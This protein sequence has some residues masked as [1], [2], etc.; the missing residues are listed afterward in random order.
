[1]RLASIRVRDFECFGADGVDVAIDDI[2]V[3]I[4]PNNVGKSAILDAYEV[5]ASSGSELPLTRFCNEVADSP[6]EITGTFVEITEGD[7]E[8]I[9]E[10]WI[11]S[12]LKHGECVKV[13][14]SWSNPGAKG[15]KSSWNNES[16][17]WV[18][19]GVGGWDSLFASCIPVPIRISPRDDPTTT[20]SKIVE[21]LT[22]A[23]KAKLKSDT[24][25][26]AAILAQLEELS[27]KFGAEIQDELD[28]TCERVSERLRCVFPDYSIEFI[29]AAGKFEPEKSVGTGSH[30][31]I[32]RGTEGAIPL[33]SQGTGLQRTFLWSA[34][35]ALAEQGK[36]KVGKSAVTPE[37]PKMLLIDEP[38]AFLHPPS[39]RAAREVLYDIAS[40]PGWQVMATTHSAVFI[41]VSKPHTTIVRLERSAGAQGSR[42]FSTDKAT[43]DGDERDRLRM[44]RSCNPTVTEFFFADHVFLVEGETEHLVLNVLLSRISEPWAGTRHVVN[45]MGKANIPLFA[46]I[47]NQFGIAYTAIHD[48]DAPQVRRNGKW[49]RNGMWTMNQR[50]S[51]A[52]AQHPDAA[53]CY[54]IVHVPDF[55]GY[56]FG[57]R[58]TADKPFS[59]VRELM[60][61][62]FQTADE[63]ARLRSLVK[64]L[65]GE[66]H[67]NT[68]TGMDGLILK[69]K[70]YVQ[71][72]SPTPAEAWTIDLPSVDA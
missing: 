24:G 23:V 7:K 67:P 47:L 33:N 51:E 38:E 69:V 29:P 63:L 40:V 11:H 26:A 31:R 4:G 39:V 43:F 6:V 46:R 70:E 41:D 52:V 8:K 61:S 2:V 27:K 49:Q 71:V 68:Y 14:W 48:A 44:I 20:E 36:L 42:V 56:Y 62:D 54:K 72:E 22:A 64:I 28:A 10:K 59:A 58:L 34:L 5:F 60:R 21:I 30:I 12:D 3:L 55:E 53:K 25:H 17:Q 19:G 45:C 18:A 37:R 50:I 66:V 16:Q 32:R 13:C 57:T 15:Q 65:S 1:M 9:G 35:G